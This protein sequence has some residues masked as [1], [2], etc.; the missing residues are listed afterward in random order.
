MPAHMRVSV[1]IPTLNEEAWI[2]RA[3][4]AAFAAG[5]AEV[6][7]CDG[8][9]TDGTI[10]IARRARA[11]VIEGERIRARQLNRGAKEARHGALIFLH[12]DTILPAGAAAAVSQALKH[13]EFGG[14]FVE[15]IE[16]GWRMRYVAFMINLRTRITRT[17]WGDQA[18]FARRASFSGYPDFPIMEDYALATRMRSKAS[19][20]RL[21]VRTS[22]RRF[23]RKGVILTSILNWTIIAA[24]HCGV[25]PVRLAR[26]YRRDQARE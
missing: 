25:S 3:I 21:R 15:M 5:A 24:Y 6:L 23:L 9:S 4:E 14:F 8:G 10:A 26:W 11:R 12:A 20:V 22:G 13:R 1:V 19:I 7:V 17:P 18:Q 16:P 2:G